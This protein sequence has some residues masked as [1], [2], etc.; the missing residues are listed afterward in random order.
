MRHIGWLLQTF[1]L[2]LSHIRTLQEEEV[3]L[4]YMVLHR[5]DGHQ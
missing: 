5:K 2:L 4:H 1:Y 3:Q